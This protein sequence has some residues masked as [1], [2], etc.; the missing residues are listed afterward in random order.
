[1]QCI[2][3]RREIDNISCCIANESMAKESNDSSRL[4]FPSARLTMMAKEEQKLSGVPPSNERAAAAGRFTS[5]HLI[6]DSVNSVGLLAGS[7]R[8][9]CAAAQTGPSVIKWRTR[10]LSDDERVTYRFSYI[11][12]PLHSFPYNFLTMRTAHR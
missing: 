3:N 1:M 5:H 7:Y 2:H 6:V 12:I 11:R 9:N 4:A 10:T 8:S